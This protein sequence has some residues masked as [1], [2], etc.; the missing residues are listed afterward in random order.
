M[1]FNDREQFKTQIPPGFSLGD[2][3]PMPLI[4]KR[5]Y[6]W[7]W[8]ILAIIIAIVAISFLIAVYLEVASRDAELRSFLKS[9]QQETTGSIIE[10]EL[11]SGLAGSAMSASSSDANASSSATAV[12]LSAGGKDQNRL[13]A[14]KPGRPQL[15]NA[16]SSLVIVEFA[17]FQCQTCLSEFP[18]IREISNAYAKD[19]LFIFRNYPVIDQN[20]MMFAQ[21]GLCANEQGKFWPFHDRLYAKQGQLATLE[22]FKQVAVMSGLDWNKLQAC[23]N[24][25][26]YKAQLMEDMSDALDLGVRGTPTFFVNGKKLEGAITKA[27]WQ[28]IIGKYK[29]LIKVTN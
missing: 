9:A 6:F 24:T 15:G 7:L 19:I 28:E 22:D 3:P 17:D 27:V 21:A 12:D 26:K 25:E 16:S 14:E 4:P 8:V 29:E 11:L 23:V 1:D 18:I 20:S 10:N 13:I 5:R 2:Y